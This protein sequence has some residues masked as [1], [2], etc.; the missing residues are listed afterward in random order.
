MAFKHFVRDSWLTASY[1]TGLSQ[2]YH[3]LAGR[4]RGVIS[5]H[6]VLPVSS[7]SVF[8]TYNVDVTASVFDKQLTFLKKHFWVLPIQEL[9]NPQAQG[10]FLTVDDGMLNNYEIL[11]PILEKHELSALFAICPAM[12][13]GELPHIWRDHL[14]LLFQQAQGQEIFL[15]ID[16]YQRSFKITSESECLNSLTRQFKKYV[17]ENQIA[18]IYGLVREICA[19][20]GWPYAQVKHDPLRY[21]FMNW[22]Q[23]QDLTKR[24]HRIASHTMTHRV[25]KFLSAEDK[26]Y[27]LAESKKRLET[28]LNVSV[29]ILVYPY[30]SMVEIDNAT[31]S[32]AREAGYQAALMN[33]QHHSL[34]ESSL[35]LPRFAFPPIADAPH[36]HA[37]VSGYKFL[38]R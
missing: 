1:Y 28:Q 20:N 14:F 6:N 33:V 9:E 34:P 18:D 37:I 3:A 4:K 12:I 8:D 19:K 15:P 16:Q 10:L 25:L 30:G 2:L 36:L 32:T 13:D 24:G 22:G 5:Y 7:L 31:V 27:E 21:Q 26:Q 11:A 23:I 35:T 38:F 29:D 17:Y